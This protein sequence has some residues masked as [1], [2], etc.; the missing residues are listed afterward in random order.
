MIKTCSNCGNSKHL[1][2]FYKRKDSVDGY[3]GQCTSCKKIWYEN[4]RKNN[5][6]SISKYNKKYRNTDHGKKTERNYYKNN[7]DTILKRKKDYA[8]KNRNK[9]NIYKNEWAKNNHNKR[10]MSNNKYRNKRYKTDL[11]YKKLITIRNRINTSIK[12]QGASKKY[13]TIDLLGCSFNFYK[14]YI[15]S[16][17]TDGMTWENHGLWHIDHKIPCASFDLNNP[18]GQKKCFHY[19]NTQPLW[20]KD[21]LRKGAKTA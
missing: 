10:L 5:K 15:E 8:I 12:R 19:S 6:Q 13:R 17:F 16:L 4:Y 9:L 2:E 3:S 1:S 21:N 11:L 18:E 20:A 14:E 7:R